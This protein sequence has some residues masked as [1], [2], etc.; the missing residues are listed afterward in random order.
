MTRILFRCLLAFMLA[1]AWGFA[2]ADDSK[3]LRKQRIDAQRERQQLV[4]DRTRELNDVT[5]IFREYTLDLDKDYRNR[6]QEL[7][8][9]FRLRRVELEAGHSARVAGAEAEYQKKLENLFANPDVEITDQ[10]IQQMAA[11]AKTFADDLFDLKKQAAEEMHAAL[12]ENEEKKNV[13]LTRRDKIA[14]KEAESLGL[15]GRY[16]PILAT[17]IGDG[18]TRLEERWNDSQRKDVAQIVDHNRKTVSEYRNGNKL[19]E[20]EIANLNE[21]FRLTWEQNARIHALESQRIFYN[22]LL[23]QVVQ[24]RQ[25]DRPK[26]MGEIA[27]LNQKQ[28]L[29]NIEY[30]SIR[31]NNRITRGLEKKEILAN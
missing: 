22:T 25:I 30:R 5:R 26:I 21:D 11:E 17:P 12:I 27:D 19:R 8:K 20:R 14:M 6:V 3:E 23:V 15:T 24:T 7:D 10:T 28:R 29:I 1:S 18:L 16:D 31:D 2:T 4:T 9:E 13:L